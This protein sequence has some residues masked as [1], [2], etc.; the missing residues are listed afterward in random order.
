MAF[1]ANDRSTLEPTFAHA[2]AKVGDDDCSRSRAPTDDYDYCET[3]PLRPMVTNW[4]C[5]PA[6]IRHP[7]SVDDRFAGEASFA[8]ELPIRACYHARARGLT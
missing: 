5:R 1:S 6:A 3:E 7:V 4:R 8:V 2:A